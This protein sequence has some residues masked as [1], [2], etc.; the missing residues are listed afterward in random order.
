[1]DSGSAAGRECGRG[2]VEFMG[3]CRWEGEGGGG[4]WVEGSGEGWVVGW[5]GG[6]GW[7]GFV[8]GLKKWGRGIGGMGRGWECKNTPIVVVTN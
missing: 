2:G 1:M 8:C 7:G 5:G 6:G 3:G 4:G